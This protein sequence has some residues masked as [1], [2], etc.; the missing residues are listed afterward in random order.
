MEDKVKNFIESGI[1]ETYV[2][3]AASAVEE[4]N[5]LYMSNHFPEVKLELEQLEADMEKF[6]YYGAIPPPPGLWHK[7]EKEIDALERIP[8][9]LNL[10]TE[11]GNYR[12]KQQQPEPPKSQFIEVDAQST[13]MRVH[14][15]WRWV[16]AAV[17]VL[18]KIFLAAAIYYYLENR[19][20]Q[21][22]L[23][24]LKQE[25]KQLKQPR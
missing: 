12:Y 23:Q 25:I 18:G 13:H 2:T 21:Q 7:I 19:Q 17:F 6:A 1:L 10:N 5:V 20:A 22:N 15:V 24:E 11:G 3:G 9:Q 16:F 14:K 8:Q 4:H